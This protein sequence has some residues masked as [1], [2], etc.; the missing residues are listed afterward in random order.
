MQSVEAQDPEE[1]LD[2]PAAREDTEFQPDLFQKN[3]ID[4]DNEARNE[5]ATDVTHRYNLRSSWSDWR[6]RYAD[7]YTTCGAEE[8]IDS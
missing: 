8:F 2:H 4:V 6:D 3:I 5:E 1:L 7:Y